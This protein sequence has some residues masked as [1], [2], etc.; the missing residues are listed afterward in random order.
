MA[1]S[2]RPSGAGGEYEARSGVTEAPLAPRPWASEPLRAPTSHV[3]APAPANAHAHA[4]PP[5]S[6]TSQ[7]ESAARPRLRLQTPFDMQS[8]PMREAPSSSSTR[9]ALHEGPSDSPRTPSPILRDFDAEA[10]PATAHLTFP[11]VGLGVGHLEQ[12]MQLL[13]DMESTDEV[14]DAADANAGVAE[15]LDV[16]TRRGIRSKEGPLV[17]PDDHSGPDR[18]RALY[19]L[20][21]CA[22]PSVG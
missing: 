2:P 19:E 3:V 17:L 20:V 6:S 22:H 15:L 12:E 9:A 14:D 8:S 1:L 7:P 21:R 11:Q 10:T 16:L 5:G 4:A 13:M 18:E